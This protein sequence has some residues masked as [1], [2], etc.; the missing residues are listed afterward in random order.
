MTY[1]DTNVLLHWLLGDHPELT[2]RAENLIDSSSPGE[3]YV[4]DVIVA[5]VIYVLRGTGRDRD[6]TAEAVGLLLR[7]E[8]FTFEHAELITVTLQLY[9]EHRL[10][11]ADCYLWARARHDQA[12]LA[13]F[14]ARLSRKFTPGT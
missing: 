14:D 4:T 2:G 9:S 10:D 7:T 11:F 1:T 13:T 12:E 8:A 5:E 6:Q 3:L